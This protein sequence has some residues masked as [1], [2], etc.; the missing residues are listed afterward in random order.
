MPPGRSNTLN[1][2]ATMTRHIITRITG[3][4]RMATLWAPAWAATLAL[5]AV[6]AT[7]RADDC[8]ANYVQCTMERSTST[9]CVNDYLDCTRGV[10][11]W[12]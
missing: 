1:P 6:P 11:R 10:I 3:N 4:A 12:Y 7:A 8:T 5:L 2:E 9:E